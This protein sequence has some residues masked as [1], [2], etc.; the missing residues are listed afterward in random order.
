MTEDLTDQICFDRVVRQHDEARKRVEQLTSGP[1]GIMEMKQTIADKERHIEK[2]EA[3]LRFYVD[4][5]KYRDD[6]RIP[7]L[8]S[9]LDFGETARAALGDK[10]E[11][12]ALRVVSE[13]EFKSALDDFNKEALQSKETAVAALQRHGLLDENGKL[14]KRYRDDEESE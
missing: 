1:G 7:D 6:A 13:E 9:E 11:S 3:A 4:P 14:A 10:K 8:Y 5:W 12:N 2:L